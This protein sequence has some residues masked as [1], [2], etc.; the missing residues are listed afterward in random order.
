[1]RKI[2]PK[3]K[4]EHTPDEFEMQALA[5]TDAEKEKWKDLKFYRGKGCVHC[6]NTGYYDRT[7]IFELLEVKG[8]IKR[9]IF[10]SANQEEIREEATRRG[11]VTLR[12]A[13][14][15]KISAGTTTVREVLRVTVQ[16]Y[17]D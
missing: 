3:C 11:M 13:A 4:I 17:D 10:D 16:E 14:F 6:R 7:G 5:M 8:P 12:E 2:C 9:L 15:R 1:V